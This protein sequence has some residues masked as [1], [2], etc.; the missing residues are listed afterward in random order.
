MAI[1]EI[2]GSWHSGEGRYAIELTMYGTGGNGLVGML[3]GGEKPHIGGVAYANPR[4]ISNGSGTTADISTVCGPGHKD[5]IVAQ[6]VA[7]KLCINVGEAV[8]VT[9]GVHIDNATAFEI[10]L[11]RQNCLQVADDFITAYQ[12]NR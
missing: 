3:C 4:P 10:D 1:N 8:C 5:V 12:K 9:A 7:K 2:L 11:L 6:L